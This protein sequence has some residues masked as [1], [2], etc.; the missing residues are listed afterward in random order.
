MSGNHESAN[1]ATPTLPQALMQTERLAYSVGEAAEFLG[2]HYFSVYRMIQ[3]SKSRGVPVVGA[4]EPQSG[5]SVS[6]TAGATGE[7]R[8][9]IAACVRGGW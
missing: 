2:V 6:L 1:V 4:N 5:I 7:G 3:R 9:C 8:G